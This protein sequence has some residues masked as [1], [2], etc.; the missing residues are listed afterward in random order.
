MS[1]REVRDFTYLGSLEKSDR[2]GVRGLCRSY[3]RGIDLLFQLPVAGAE[4]DRSVSA[5]LLVCFA[6]EQTAWIGRQRSVLSNYHQGQH[7]YPLAFRSSG[8]AKCS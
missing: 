3:V 8:A 7:L 6:S 1:L 5:F 4:S 2:A